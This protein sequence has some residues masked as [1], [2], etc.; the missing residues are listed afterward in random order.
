MAK[1]L[2]GT[3]PDQVPTNA[4]LGTIA[5]QDA[6][7]LGPLSTGGNVLVGT[8]N[9]SPATDDVAGIKLSNT[10]AIQASVDGNAALFVNRKGVGD[11]TL[12]DFRH[13][14]DQVGSIGTRASLLKIGSGDTGITFNPTNDSIFPEDMGGTFRDAA[15][16][17]GVDAA[18]FR[19]LRL[20]GGVYLGGTGAANLLDDYEEG[21]W[22]PVV[23][24]AITGGNTGGFAGYSPSGTYT[25]IGRMVYVTCLL[26]GVTTTGMTG[27]NTLVIRGLPFTVGKEAFGT[28]STYRVS[29]NADT[30]S[31]ASITPVSGTH[32]AF[33]YFVADSAVT[34]RATLV[35]DVVSNVST[36]EFT[37]AYQV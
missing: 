18:R 9:I 14:G 31:S 30:V 10:G 17:L 33:P 11:G 23:A 21:T 26:N 4:D 20:S 29:R 28:Y 32:V 35:S 12:V 27:A 22:T 15:I 7:N 2:Y 19:N 24:D 1:K 16:D 5:Y 34:G 36:V 3:D 37:I 25:K 6:D 8:T 13:Q